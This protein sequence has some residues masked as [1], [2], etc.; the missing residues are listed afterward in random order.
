MNQFQY[1][2]R[3]ILVTGGCGFIGS[4]F[5]RYILRLESAPSI[6]NLDSLTY[7]GNINNLGEEF[8]NEKHK[9]I[10]G[11]ITDKSFV[12]NIFEQYSPDTVINFA[13]ESHVD[14]SID[15]PLQFFE[16]NVV[17]TL[18]LL[19]ISLTLGVKRFL[20][21]STDEVYGSLG[22]KGLFTE[23]SPLSPN[24]PYS[25]SKAS[26]DNFVNAYNHTYGLDTIITRCSN[27]YGPCQ[28]PEKLIPLV[29]KLATKNSPIPVYGDG[30]NVRDW[31]HVYDHCRGIW[32]A[33]RRGISG[34]IFNFG[35][36]CELSNLVLVK[37]I[38]EIMDKSSSLINFVTDRK[39]H[40]FRYA[41]DSSKAKK[42][43]GWEPVKLFDR[44]IVKTIDWYLSNTN[45]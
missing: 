27:N 32:D 14:R 15:N 37:R 41:I 43:L 29:I 21:V 28:Y 36:N 24:S 31:I 44:E 17:G 40:D 10:E 8:T 30:T 13:A 39:G 45:Y 4:N 6:I 18:N 34:E 2:P 3:K 25:A 5:I 22:K 23:T 26:A 33:L 19:D 38:L 1:T 7:A 42:V 16:T 12:T 35:G 20:Q 11:D 9:F